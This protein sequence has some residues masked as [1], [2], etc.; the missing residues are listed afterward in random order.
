MA[1]QS[2]GR[3]NWDERGIFH[4]LVR[5][6]FPTSV[7]R[8]K[9]E[10][11]WDWE[12]E[13][14]EGEVTEENAAQFVN[15]I[16]NG[17][18]PEAIH[19]PKYATQRDEL[20]QVA[21]RENFVESSQYKSKDEGHPFSLGG[22]YY[23]PFQLFRLQNAVEACLI[24][25]SFTD[26]T[27]SSKARAWFAR[28]LE[29]ALQHLAQNEL[30]HLKTL[31]LLAL[32]EDRYLP[33]WRGR[34]H[35]ILVKGSLRDSDVSWHEFEK[36]FDA[37]KLL[38]SC[39]LSRDDIQTIREDLAWRG[40]CLD[41]NSSFYLLFRHFSHEHR[42]RLEGKALLAWDYYEA[43]ELIGWF[44]RDATGENQGATDDLGRSNGWWKK[45]DFGI[46]AHEIDFDAGNIL[47]RLLHDYALNPIY[48]LLWIVEGESEAQF[49]STWC[50]IEGWN[51]D[52]IG[53]RLLI[54]DGIP[55]LKAKSTRQAIAQAQR[56]QAGV[57]V[58]VDDELDAQKVINQWVQNGWI[59]RRLSLEDWKTNPLPGGLVWSPCFEDA[60]FTLDQLLE[61]FLVFVAQNNQ[62]TGASRTVDWAT[63]RETTE[64]LRQNP[65]LDKKTGQ[66]KACDSWI[67]A[68]TWAARQLH[69]PQ[70]DKPQ[71]AH[72]L[73]SR[74]GREDIPIV[75]LLYGCRH[76]A[77][78]ATNYG[79]PR[80]DGGFGFDYSE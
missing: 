68:L 39:A 38:E 27:V 10:A 49:I 23:H 4:P 47:N 57:L 72:L 46:E 60:N 42:Q 30:W 48:K 35:Q 80:P 7:H 69:L 1:P 56:D 52:L 8:K 65:P 12:T 77:E 18:T 13:P 51:L 15:V 78:L 62:Q 26:F 66:P 32:I 40:Q 73:A 44:L 19:A 17:W 67:T 24:R 71:L 74:Y 45:R 14:F 25:C 22:V 61:T 53:I 3:F 55:G 9:S 34:R 28:D 36:Q 58:V 50:E 63:L 20:L 11:H 79:P 75:Q 31:Y 59:A 21:T 76:I 29:H 5:Y 2:G 16:A 70:L 64:K 43:A 33:H 6:R 54:L 37:P 41:P